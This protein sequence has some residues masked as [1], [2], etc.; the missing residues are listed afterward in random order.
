M[1]Y[2]LTPERLL[3]KNFLTLSSPYKI[4]KHVIDNKIAAHWHDFFEMGFVVSGTGTHVI[5]G[6]PFPLEKGMTFLLTTADFHEIIPDEGQTIHLFNLIFDESFIRPELTEMLFEQVS[7]HLHTF[8]DE[9]ASE[10]EIEFT[11]IWNESQMWQLGSSMLVQ[12]S[13]ERILIHLYRNNGHQRLLDDYVAIS[14]IPSSIRKSI[15]YIQHHFREPLSLDEIARYAGISANYFS[16]CFK[17]HTGTSFQEHLQGKRLQFAS[18]LLSSSI[19]PITEVCY[20]AGFNT[21]P[22]FERAFKKKFEKSPREFR[23]KYIRP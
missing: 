12:G 8:R 9:S 5:N 18:A 15:I 2:E 19:L 23:R 17:K 11:R 16:E 21:L 4:Y 3:G 1:K 10:I 6:E 7:L 14:A 13:F 20:A 22:N